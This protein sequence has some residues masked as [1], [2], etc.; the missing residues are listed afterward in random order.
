[1]SCIFLFP[2]LLARHSI[3]LFSP[4]SY[5]SKIM[6]KVPTAHAYY[7]PPMLIAKEIS[8]NMISLSYTPLS[9]FVRLT[10]ICASPFFPFPSLSSTINSPY[11]VPA[12]N[13][14]YKRARAE[15][16]A[17]KL[18]DSRLQNYTAPRLFLLCLPLSLIRLAAR[19]K[20]CKAYLIFSG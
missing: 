10:S 9:F 8:G 15:P 7:Y 13:P 17:E 5:H 4:G 14:R 18:R 11:W 19:N 6:T 20:P 1:M 3:S 12:H 2:S 16:E